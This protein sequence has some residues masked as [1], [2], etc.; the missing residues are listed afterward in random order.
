M[1]ACISRIVKRKKVIFFVS[2]FFLANEFEIC[3]FHVKTWIYLFFQGVTYPSIHAIW[4]KWA[5]PMEKTRLA[6]FAFSGLMWKFYNYYF[7]YTTKYVCRYCQTSTCFNWSYF[8]VYRYMKI[9][10]HLWYVIEYS[11]WWP[12]Y[13]MASLYIMLNLMVLMVICCEHQSGMPRNIH[14]YMY[15]VIKNHNFIH[16]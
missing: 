3:I 1:C 16:R 14:V 10:P 7:V 2:S 9:R 8:S 6:A 15:I 13:N 5:P 4:A 12:K 11:T